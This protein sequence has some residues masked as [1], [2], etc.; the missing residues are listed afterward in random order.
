MIAFGAR[1]L[2]GGFGVFLAYDGVIEIP[3]SALVI[4]RPWTTQR[5][6][7]PARSI[8]FDPDE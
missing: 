2:H 7:P 5:R 3:R 1:L 8:P 6:R 4:A